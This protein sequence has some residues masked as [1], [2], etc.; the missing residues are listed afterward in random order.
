MALDRF[1]EKLRDGLGKGTEASLMMKEEIWRNIRSTIESEPL[2]MNL[3]KPEVNRRTER[4]RKTALYAGSIAAAVLIMFVIAPAQPT[5]ALI[6]QIKDWFAPS[7]VV[8]QQ[9]E[10]IPSKS[11]ATLH[12]GK[13]GYVIYFDKKMYKMTTVDGKDRIVPTRHTDERYPE[14]YMEITQ[15]TQSPDKAAEGIHTQ[16]KH[17]PTVSEV[18]EVQLPIPAREIHAVGGKGGKAWNDEVVRFYVFD[19]NKGGSFVIRQQYFLEAE[20]GHGER[21]KQMLKEFHITDEKNG[22]GEKQR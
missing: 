10:G 7:K 22:T 17:Y 9:I 18:R 13:S 19:N 8:E 16:L 12:E 20:E 15:Q 6:S 5:Q 4:R 11:N 1:E 3:G 2:E 14:V 21:F